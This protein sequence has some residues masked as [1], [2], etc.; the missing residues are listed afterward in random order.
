MMHLAT[1]IP[2]ISFCLLPVCAVI[3]LLQL[4]VLKKKMGPCEY[5][6]PHKFRMQFIGIM[7]CAPVLIGL[8]YFRNFDALTVFAICGVGVLGFYI[9]FH[10]I[11]YMSVGG[12]YENGLIW[13]SA[14]LFYDTI[15]TVSHFEKTTIEIMTKDRN[16]KCI[17]F[18]NQKIISQII[19]KLKSIGYPLQ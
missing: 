3:L 14:F 11:L 12:I 9:A 1:I 8:N 2:A 15:D 18:E 4:R 5:I 13:N 6:F 16:K 19:E 10:D 17:E 7:V